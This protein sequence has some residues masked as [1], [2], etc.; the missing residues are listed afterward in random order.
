MSDLECR[1]SALHHLDP[2]SLV[3]Q[4][5]VRASIQFSMIADTPAEAALIARVI[6]ECIRHITP[7]GCT[8]TS[9][10]Q[11]FRR[12]ARTSDG[13]ELSVW[14]STPLEVT[15]GSLDLCKSIVSWLKH[16]F[17][18]EVICQ[19]SLTQVDANT[20]HAEQSLIVQHDSASSAN[21]SQSYQSLPMSPKA[22][23]KSAAPE[24]SL[25]GIDAT[26][27]PALDD[28]SLYAGV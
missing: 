12:D 23:G 25:L 14:R 27:P 22:G 20:Y 5:I 4:A 8:I 19:W 1:A 7:S 15:H 24:Q 3:H 26:G 18:A 28:Q 6:R 10:N 21:E 13:V 2:M 17:K 9:D 16:Y 11:L